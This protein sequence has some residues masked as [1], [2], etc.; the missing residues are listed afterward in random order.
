VFSPAVVGSPVVNSPY[1]FYLA[2]ICRAAPPAPV[3]GSAVLQLASRRNPHSGAGIFL[4]SPI[5]FL[6]IFPADNFHRRFYIDDCQ[7]YA[8]K[9]FL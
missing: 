9:L 8:W 7:F 1:Q 2:R 5:I 6:M 4:P 3:T